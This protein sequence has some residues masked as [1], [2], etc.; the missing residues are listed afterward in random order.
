VWRQEG[1]ETA[2][3]I[4]G[5]ALFLS[6]ACSPPSDRAVTAASLWWCGGRSHT[7]VPAPA[8]RASRPSRGQQ[9]ARR[10]AAPVTALFLLLHQAALARQY[11]ARHMPTAIAGQGATVATGPATVSGV[12][13]S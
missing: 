11:R 8:R 7:P 9:C 4:F 12:T 10:T 3:T 6:R 1:R 13:Q 2:P 5:A